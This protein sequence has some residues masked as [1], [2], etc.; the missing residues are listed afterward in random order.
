MR[1]LQGVSGQAGQPWVL[2]QALRRIGVDAD[3]CSIADHKFG[4]PTHI[5]RDVQGISTTSQAYHRLRDL[6]DQYD[7]FHFHARTFL[8]SWPD[9]PYPTLHDLILLRL[10]GKKVFFHFRGQ[11]VRMAE[12]FKSLNPFHY[13]D[14]PTGYLFQRM[15]DVSKRLF[16][17]AI[18]SLSDGVFVVDEELETYVPG[19]TVVPRALEASDWSYVGVSERNIPIIVHAPSRRGVKGTQHVIDAVASLRAEGFACELR[20][21]ENMSHS[22]AAAVYRD[23]D[24]IV[25]QLRIGW[26]GVLA[27]EA[28]ALG[29]PTV[30]Y[31]RDD[32]YAKHGGKLPIVNASP[33]TLQ[34]ELRNLVRSLEQRKMLSGAS[35]RYFETVHSAD[36]VATQ[37]VSLYS[38]SPPQRDLT[39]LVAL[40]ASQDARHHQPIS[41]TIR[42]SFSWRVAQQFHDR[43]RAEGIHAAMLW[44]GS[45]VARRVSRYIR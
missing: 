12:Q 26:Y 38:A 23:A 31:I 17:G 45:G 14:E 6:I 41:Q 30:T 19:A 22:E 32:L 5:R 9:L 36:V 15:P 20:L 25:D 34:E 35:R 13:V 1:V 28:M 24:I 7:V 18:R 2:A 37:L 44:L 40:L 10:A 21:V 11:E 33:L 16:I 3:S 8:T 43:I 4:Y 39:G 29:K 27:V 42:S